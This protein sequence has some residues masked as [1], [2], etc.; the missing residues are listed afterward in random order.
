MIL[1]SFS[2]IS[3]F[4]GSSGSNNPTLSSAK[5]YDRTFWP[6]SFFC[7]QHDPILKQKK[8][9]YLLKIKQTFN[10]ETFVFFIYNKIFQRY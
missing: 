4:S 10:F 6:L 9:Y 7:T 8:Y 1:F 2:N 5:I 3:H